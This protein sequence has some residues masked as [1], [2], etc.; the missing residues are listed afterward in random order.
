MT[1]TT[2]NT[3]MHKSPRK[4]QKKKKTMDDLRK[5]SLLLPETKPEHEIVSPDL[6]VPEGQTTHE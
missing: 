1:T 2:N 5:P 4:T 3:E 6:N